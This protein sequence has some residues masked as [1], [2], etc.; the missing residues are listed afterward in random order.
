MEV[1]LR[2]KE[3][4]QESDSEAVSPRYARSATRSLHG[5]SAG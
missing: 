3:R 4:G 5:A 1:L 2:G